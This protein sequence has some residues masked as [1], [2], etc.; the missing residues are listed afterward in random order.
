M[1]QFWCEFTKEVLTEFLNEDYII[2][3]FSLKPNKDTDKKTKNP[4]LVKQNTEV[5]MGSVNASDRQSFKKDLDQAQLSERV[6]II[7]E[8]I[9]EEQKDG[10]S[11]E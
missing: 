9:A 7:N 6:Q 8:H 5:A 11:K 10:L 4:A 1:A 2:K 3:D